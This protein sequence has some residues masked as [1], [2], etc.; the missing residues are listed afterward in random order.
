MTVGNRRIEPSHILVLGNL[1]MDRDM[2]EGRFGNER[3]R[4]LACGHG[5]SLNAANSVR[6]RELMSW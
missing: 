1:H 4:L 3:S 2:Q 6:R 5:F